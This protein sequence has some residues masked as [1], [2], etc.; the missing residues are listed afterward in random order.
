VTPDPSPRAGEGHSWVP[1]PEETRKISERGV[2]AECPRRRTNAWGIELAANLLAPLPF[3]AGT[4]F[5]S[6]GYL[7]VALSTCKNCGFIAA[8]ALPTLGITI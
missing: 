8:H 2:I 6:S 3:P 5:P 1:T 4:P 7:P